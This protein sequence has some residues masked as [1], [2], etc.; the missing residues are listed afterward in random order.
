MRNIIVL[1]ILYG[2]RM[3]VFFDNEAI[4]KMMEL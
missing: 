4:K 2:I 3:T 1:L